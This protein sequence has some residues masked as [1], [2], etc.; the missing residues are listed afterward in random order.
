MM[1]LSFPLN[2][3]HLS[4]YYYLFLVYFPWSPSFNAVSNNRN[5]KVE[6]DF[7]LL[8]YTHF[9]LIAQWAFS[10][11]LSSSLNKSNNNWCNNSIR[12]GRRGS[13]EESLPCLDFKDPE[14]FRG[15][16]VTTI[17]FFCIFVAYRL[18]KWLLVHRGPFYLLSR[19]RI[20][21]RRA[22]IKEMNNTSLLLTFLVKD[23]EEHQLPLQ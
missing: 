23:D 6:N 19:I 13:L 1:K 10:A 21:S 16:T 4:H 12:R 18:P 14:I 2:K 7:L 20:F 17:N 3:P 22:W 5:S 15:F 8:L 11:I 9:F